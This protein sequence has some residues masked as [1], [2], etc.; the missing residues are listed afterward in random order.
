YT[1][2]HSMV[3]IGTTKVTRM[4]SSSG[5]T[6]ANASSRLRRWAVA[7]WWA[8]PTVRECRSALRAGIFSP[9]PPRPLGEAATASLQQP[10][11]ELLTQRLAVVSPELGAGLDAFIQMRG[12]QVGGCGRVGQRHGRLAGRAVG[13]VRHAGQRLGT[14]GV[15]DELHGQLF[16]LRALDDGPGV[17]VVDVAV[18]DDHE[19]LLLLRD[20]VVEAAVGRL[21]QHRAAVV[22]QLWGLRPGVEPDDVLL[23]AVELGEGALLAFRRGQHFVDFLGGYAV[24][25]QRPFH[26][27]LRA[28]AHGALARNLAQVEEVADAFGLGAADGAFIE[29]EHHGPDDV[30]HGAFTGQGLGDEVLCR[31][32]AVN[33]GRQHAV[34]EGFQQALGAGALEVDHFEVDHV[35]LDV[36]RLDLGLD[37][38]HATG[39]VLEQ[40]LDASVLLIGI[41]DV[42]LLRGTVRPAPGH[43]G[44]AFLSRGAA[45]C[46]TQCRHQGK[47]GNAGSQ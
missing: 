11:V 27:H 41:D 46:E 47:G 19:R 26:V 31:R 25:H 3:P 21:H 45:C 12:R 8:S 37:L 42:L 35:P 43:R 7:A 18:P 22:E 15:L 39:V 5:A 29:G 32:G 30:A 28:F 14:G 36:A 24:G 1:L 16:L 9:W 17:E 23:D 2:R 4:N 13:Y 44:E 34:V 10:L 33:A 6:K 40:H 38:G 20:G